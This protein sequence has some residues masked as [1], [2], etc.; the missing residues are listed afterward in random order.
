MEEICEEVQLPP[1]TRQLHEASRIELHGHLVWLAVFVVFAIWRLIM[2][3][4]IARLWTKA[5]A[6]IENDKAMAR[7]SY[8]T[9]LEMLR[10]EINNAP[11]APVSELNDDDRAAIADMKTFVGE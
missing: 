9:D 3:G 11:P 6:K 5:K 1:S 7:S 2:A 10:S 4:D 8:N